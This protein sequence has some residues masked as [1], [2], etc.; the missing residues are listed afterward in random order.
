MESGE[1]LVCKKDSTG[2]VRPDTRVNEG[3]Q[4]ETR[5]GRRSEI[6]GEV[7]AKDSKWQQM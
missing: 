2:L 7:E 3:E 5:L 1:H 4:R 6:Q